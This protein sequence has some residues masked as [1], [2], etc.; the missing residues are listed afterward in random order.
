MQRS[1]EA[2]VYGGMALDKSQLWIVSHQNLLPTP[3]PGSSSNPCQTLGTPSQ[4]VSNDRLSRE[5]V[6]SKDSACLHFYVPDGKSSRLSQLSPKCS[7]ML[8]QASNVLFIIRLCNLM[9]KYGTPFFRMDRIT[10]DLYAMEVNSMTLISEKATIMPKVSTSA[11]VNSQYPSQM[12]SP[13]SMT[14]SSLTLPAAK[15]TQVP[16]V[17]RVVVGNEERGAIGSTSLSITS[18]SLSTSSELANIDLTQE[19]FDEERREKRKVR[20]S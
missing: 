13:P 8:S 6:R 3:V 12:F 7:G 1:L 18:H 16:Q 10:V 4:E 11:G 2:S 17:D 5:G 9:E 20:V 15:F 14:D 19:M